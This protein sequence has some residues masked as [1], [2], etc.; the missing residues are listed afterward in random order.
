M[1]TIARPAIDTT[2]M[3]ETVRA[4][5]SRWTTSPDEGSESREPM[6]V[7]NSNAPSA[8]GFRWSR[9]RICGT[10]DKS[11]AIETPARMNTV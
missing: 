3:I 4:A 7:I 10:R 8:P 11:D 5:P 1:A 9:S 6:A 2:D